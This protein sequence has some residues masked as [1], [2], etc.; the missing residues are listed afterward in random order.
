MS[1]NGKAKRKSEEKSIPFT[2]EEFSNLLERYRNCIKAIC[3]AVSTKQKDN[4][5][6]R[7][8]KLQDQQ[9]E[10]GEKKVPDELIKDVKSK[11]DKSE[12]ESIKAKS[13]EKSIPLTTEEFSNPLERY[14]N[15]TKWRGIH[16]KQV[17]HS[18]LRYEPPVPCQDATLAVLEPLPAIF[19]ADGAGSARLSHLGSQAVVKKLSEFITSQ[20]E[21]SIYHEL[22]DREQEINEEEGKKYAYTLIKRAVERLR[23]LSKEEEHPVHAFKCTLVIAVLGKNRLFWLKVGDG[24]IVAEKDNKLELVGPLGKGE[25]AN[26]TTFVSDKIKDAD[27][28][29]GFLPSHNITGIA[30]FTDG[31]GET[32]VSTDGSRI[33]GALSKFFAQMRDGKFGEEELTQFLK[34]PKVWAPPKGGDDRGMALLARLG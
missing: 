18:H 31:A 27:I 29:Y 10:L 19:V 4:F 26:Q 13:E 12:E 28:H 1:K 5:Y 32:L 14:P 34:D 2:T 20:G 23:E 7:L 22:L 16:A 15:S 21:D 33:A 9:K 3:E 11:T 17:G 25:F 8:G 30:A 6:I 24:F